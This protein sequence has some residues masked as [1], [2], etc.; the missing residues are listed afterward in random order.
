M[1]GKLFSRGRPLLTYAV[2]LYAA[3]LIISPFEHHDLICHLKTP[4]HCSACTSNQLSPA[5]HAPA[6]V[7][8]G[9]LSD[10]GCAVVIHQNADGVLLSVSSCGRSPPAAR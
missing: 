9:Q 10:A 4:L 5:P 3:F 2:A 1:A 7:G 6:A 8:V